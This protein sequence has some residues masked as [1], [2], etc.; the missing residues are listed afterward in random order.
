M[1]KLLIVVFCI[2][3]LGFSACTKIVPYYKPEIQQGNQI[4]QAQVGKLR[5]GMTQQDV[6]KI[7]G[8]PVV[9]PGFN[10]NQ[11]VYINTIKSSDKPTSEQRLVLNFK[12][13]QL[14]SGY[15]DFRLSF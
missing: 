1:R 8:N 15:G 13:D 12:N 10:R 4:T 11:L 9:Q 2:T 5:H 6:I 7:L 3:I 14:A